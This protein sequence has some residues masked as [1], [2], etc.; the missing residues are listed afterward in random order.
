MAAIP[1]MIGLPPMPY[2]A[3]PQDAHLPHLPHLPHLHANA[4]ALE[5]AHD[6]HRAQRALVESI[7][8]TAPMPKLLHASTSAQSDGGW[9]DSAASQATNAFVTAT[10]RLARVLATVAPS[11]AAGRAA[12]W[13]ESAAA[14]NSEILH[15]AHPALPSWTAH[16]AAADGTAEVEQLLAAAQGGLA[17]LALSSIPQ[18]NVAP[19]GAPVGDITRS[20]RGRL[21]T[22]ST[23]P[24]TTNINTTTAT[25]EKIAMQSNREAES[26]PDFDPES[27]A[28]SSGDDDDDD[29]DSSAPRLAKRRRSEPTRKQS[30]P[31]RVRQRQPL[32]PGVLNAVDTNRE[33]RHMQGQ[34]HGQE[35][36]GGTGSEKRAVLE[37]A[38]N[39]VVDNKEVPGVEVNEETVSMACFLRQILDLAFSL[40]PPPPQPLSHPTHAAAVASTSILGESN[41][42]T[43]MG[44]NRVGGMGTDRAEAEGQTGDTAESELALLAQ[45]PQ[46]TLRA[47]AEGLLRR[48][49]PVVP[50]RL[51]IA[52]KGVDALASGRFRVQLN[53]FQLPACLPQYRSEGRGKRRAGATKVKKFSKNTADLYEVRRGG[54]G[55]GRERSWEG[56]GGDGGI[57]Q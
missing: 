15:P 32:D 38:V 2:S 52:L 50:F 26:D 3:A 34:G 36:R 39:L 16:G 20:H 1:S 27:S 14:A 40:S 7:I 46:S 56:T 55:K 25:P 10:A 11:R 5:V 23:P 21:K 9:E 28:C 53:T 49:Q 33:H 13:I 29:D 24:P 17:A 18:D 37:S 51:S 4:E 42:P 22:A 41:M 31:Q 35:I 19:A 43:T 54:E 6:L 57:L 44:G 47:T 48:D 12:G 30:Q 45:L 8:Q